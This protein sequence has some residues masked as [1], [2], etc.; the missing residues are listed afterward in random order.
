[1]FP[2]NTLI[3]CLLITLPLVYNKDIYHK[4]L[5]YRLPKSILPISYHITLEPIL[6]EYNTEKDILDP[7]NINK[8]RIV[9]QTEANND[10]YKNKTNGE[11]KME[12]K[13]RDFPLYGSVSME[14]LVLQPT[15]SITLHK[16]KTLKI[17]ESS[18]SVK[19]INGNTLSIYNTSYDEETDFYIINLTTELIQGGLYNLS[20]SGYEGILQKDNAGFYLAAYTDADGSVRYVVHEHF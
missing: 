7:I 16:H 19:A 1:M 17:N 13:N 3:I 15:K 18:I 4:K 10:N 2:H 8:N 9:E 6:D 11:R 20:I 5:N 14:F 12:V